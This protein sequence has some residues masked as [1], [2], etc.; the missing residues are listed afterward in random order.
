MPSRTT[1]TPS[2]SRRVI[3]GAAVG[4]A[5]A[6][7]APLAASAHVELDASSTAPPRSAS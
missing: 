5:L 6:L 2:A 3:A 4:L 1:R 7:S